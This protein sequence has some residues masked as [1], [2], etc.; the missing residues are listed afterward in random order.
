MHRSA[1]TL[2]NLA[3][4][5]PELRDRLASAAPMQATVAEF[6]ATHNDLT[7]T[8][9]LVY[10]STLASIS[11]KR[12]NALLEGQLGQDVV[13]CL[14]PTRGAGIRLRALLAIRNL[15]CGSKAR[16]LVL[17]SRAPDTI[18]RLQVLSKDRTLK[19]SFFE[20]ADDQE[21]GV[22]KEAK[23]LLK[24]L[25]RVQSQQPQVELLKSE[26]ATLRTKAKTWAIE[27]HRRLETERRAAHTAAHEREPD[28]A[29]TTADANA[30]GDHPDPH[31]ANLL[32]PGQEYPTGTGSSGSPTFAVTPEAAGPA[33][34][35][36]QTPS[37]HASNLMEL[38]ECSIED[39]SAVETSPAD[40]HIHR[41]M[42][43]RRRLLDDSDSPATTSFDVDPFFMSPEADA[44]GD[45]T[46]N[47]TTPV[48]GASPESAVI[49]HP[50]I[51]GAT[52][53]L[54]MSS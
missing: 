46:P 44:T 49:T 40:T 45:L 22:R 33:V 37:T 27:N 36:G 16:Q 18:Q 10:V 53:A 15:V 28:R 29:P 4:A 2:I 6:F 38:A 11:E 52:D 41:M 43:P 14:C 21:S 19:E 47:T 31:T 24:I 34:G 26:L 32:G 51:G 54:F 20:K 17:L 23:L 35:T 48:K 9:A 1:A 5:V 3:L 39:A 12:K 30:A 13:D 25:I 50:S 42:S 8:V 7:T